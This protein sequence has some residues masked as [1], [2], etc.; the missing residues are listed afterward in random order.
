MSEDNNGGAAASAGTQGG[1]VAKPV[2]SA[3]VEALL[4]KQLPTI[5]N[6]AVASHLKRAEAKWEKQF[7]ALRTPQKTEEELAAEAAAQAEPQRSAG[8]SGSQSGQ[9]GADAATL[10]LEEHPMFQE[11]K[12]QSDA[13][14][15]ELERMQAQRKEEA[16]K[17]AEATARERKTRLATTVDTLLSKVV[18]PG[19]AAHARALLT[20]PDNNRIQY[21]DE[22]SDN[23]VFIDDNGDKVPLDK[24]LKLWLKTDD[25]KHFLPPINPGGSGGGPGNVLG[26]G[27]NPNDPRN[28]LTVAVQRLLNG[29]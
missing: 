3:D 22:D 15:K 12:K 18:A 7:A 27:A 23:L 6:S 20:H 5:V 19:R 26:F 25:A 10:K 29:E 16:K 13:Q 17:A 2:T 24:G 8:R 1:D 9:Q 4:T 28:K 21:E 14:R 11:L